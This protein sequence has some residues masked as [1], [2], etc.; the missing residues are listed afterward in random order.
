MGLAVVAL[1][2]IVASLVDGL[3]RRAR[4]TGRKGGHAGEPRAPEDERVLNGD[5][6]PG[7]EV[8]DVEAE[9][10]HPDLVETGPALTDADAEPV[11]A[12]TGRG[13]PHTGD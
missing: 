9:G 3:A 5:E 4:R 1:S 11:G 8:A 6:G 12:S 13:R 7:A 10:A 2:L